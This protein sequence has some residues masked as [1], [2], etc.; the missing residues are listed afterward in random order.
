MKDGSWDDRWAN[1][2]ST[3]DGNVLPVEIVFQGMSLALSKETILR[4]ALTIMLWHRL[5]YIL[6]QHSQS[7]KQ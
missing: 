3:Q 1:G 2:L 6:V 7:L 4:V 5:S